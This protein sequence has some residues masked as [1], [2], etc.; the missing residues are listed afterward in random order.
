MIA[1]L[2]N[3]ELVELKFSNEQLETEVQWEH[4][5]EFEYRGQM[6]DVVSRNIVGDSTQFFCWWDYEETELNK[7]LT[8]L[9]Q[10]AMGQRQNNKSSNQQ[11][12]LRLFMSI[13]FYSNPFEWKAFFTGTENIKTLSINYFWKDVN[14]SEPSPPPEILV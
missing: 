13:L 7:K 14:T 4:S 5:K 8:S 6:Y 2:K 10:L 9:V 11:N 12:Q 3:S 1:G